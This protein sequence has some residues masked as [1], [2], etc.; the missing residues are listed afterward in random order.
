LVRPKVGSDETKITEEH[1]AVHLNPGALAQQ[2][3]NGERPPPNIVYGDTTESARSLQQALDLI[4]Q[5][6]DRF[7]S[8]PAEV[9]LAARND[10]VIFEEMLG[11]E[12]GLQEIH[13]AGLEIEGFTP[14]RPSSETAAQPSESG[15]KEP[16]G[17]A[18]SSPPDGGNA[19]QANGAG[20]ETPAP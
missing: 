16:D 4:E 15:T 17:S 5:R 7:D 13:N 9:R 18:D 12:E 2:V 11:T 20:G 14:S 10:I 8:L 19:P 1:H 6:Q 3:M